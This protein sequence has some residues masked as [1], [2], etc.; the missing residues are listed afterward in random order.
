VV[1]KFYEGKR[2]LVTGAAGFV[3]SHLVNSLASLGAEVI[4]STHAK[5]PSAPNSAVEYV[6]AD[7]TE[8]ND[9]H[10]IAEGVDYIFMAAANT[11]GAAVMEKSPLVHLTPNVVMNSYM[12]EAAYAA[13]VEKFCF[14]SSNTVYPLTDF[15][16]RECDANFE[17][18]EKYF[19]VGWMKQFSELMCEMYSKHINEPMSTLIAR[20]GNLYG[21]HDKYTWKESKVIAALIRRAVERHD[22]FVVWG[23]GND[24]KDFLYIDDFVDGLLR[25][26][27][28]STEY[29]VFN[30]AS[31]QPVTIREVLSEILVAADYGNASVEYDATK[32][33]MIPRR[34]I[35]IDQI[36]AR[37]DWS[38]K[39]PLSEGIRRTVEWYKAE[40]R[41]S[42]PEDRTS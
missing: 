32:P 17:F 29:E 20:P 23:D 25:S 10:R 19:I 36:R 14:I 28:C 27:A 1:K 22:P 16:V 34:M 8:R 24:L 6:E 15:P 38:P 37:C 35:N 21:P 41:D 30:I 26:F 12:L 4:G 11:S 9:C 5:E 18:F 2:V 39:V 33:T 13:D 40:Y 42:S 31:G 3:G 7:L